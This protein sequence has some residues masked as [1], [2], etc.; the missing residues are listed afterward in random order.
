MSKT[1]CRKCQFYHFV[2]HTGLGDDIRCINP[3]FREVVPQKIVE[4]MGMSL[5]EHSTF[6]REGKDLVWYPK[7]KGDSCSLFTSKNWFKRILSILIA[8]GDENV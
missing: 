5:Y 4:D 6:F 8:G 2:Q 1:Q 3:E 7:I